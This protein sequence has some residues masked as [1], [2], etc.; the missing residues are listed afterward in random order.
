[1][2]IRWALMKTHYQTDRMWTDEL[3]IE[4]ELELAAL[5]SCI[6]QSVVAPTQDL[7]EKIVAS[8]ADDL[9]TPAVILALNTWVGQTGAGDS[10]GDVQSLVEFLDSLL[11]IKI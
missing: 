7:I 4:A 11:G 9:N 8:L 6:S 1:M 10:G 5:R 2:A 3:L